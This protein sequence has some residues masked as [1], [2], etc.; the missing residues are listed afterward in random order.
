MHRLQHG[1]LKPLCGFVNHQQ[2]LPAAAPFHRRHQPP[3]QR[4]LVTPLLRNAGAACGG[5]DY[6][7]SVTGIPFLS[8]VLHDGER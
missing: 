4:Q 3:A 6:K 1:L 8:P 5:N 2:H 7:A